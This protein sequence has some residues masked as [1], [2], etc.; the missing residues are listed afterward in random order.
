LFFGLVFFSVGLIGGLVEI[1][2]LQ[3]FRAALF[4][5]ISPRYWSYFMVPIFWGVAFW[6]VLDWARNFNFIGKRLYFIRLFIVIISLLSVVLIGGWDK[7]TRIWLIL[8]YDIYWSNVIGPVINFTSMGIFSWK[9]LI[10]PFTVIVAIIFLI[11][12]TK[13]YGRQK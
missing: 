7:A 4:Y 12:I 6:L 1:S 13:K 11:F 5:L 9:I 8:Y 2:V 3:F 10:L